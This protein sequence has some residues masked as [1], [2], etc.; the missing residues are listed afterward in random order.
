M[1][2]FSLESWVRRESAKLSSEPDV[3]SRVIGHA[4]DLSVGWD[5]DNDITLGSD[6][7]IRLRVKDHHSAQALFGTAGNSL[8]EIRSTRLGAIEFNGK[9]RA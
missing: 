9:F 1:V 3:A 5:V 7:A 8:G 2:I 4:N 6:G